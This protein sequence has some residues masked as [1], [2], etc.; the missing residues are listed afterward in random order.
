M[1]QANNTQHER[2]SVESNEN[3]ISTANSACLSEI[4]TLDPQVKVGSSPKRKFSAHYKQQIIDDYNAC[5][6]TQDRGALLRREG[7][8]SSHITTWRKLFSSE[9]DTKKGSNKAHR[10]EHL[11]AEIEQLKK[12]LAQ[13]QAIIDLQKKVSELLG[14]YILPHESKGGRS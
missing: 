10:N 5:S 3:R 7:L 12:K 11:V 1:D 13:A 9:N 2:N 8:Y 4:S 6:N 14:T